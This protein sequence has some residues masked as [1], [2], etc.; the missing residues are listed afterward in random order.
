MIHR[1]GT[2]TS[3]EDLKIA[4]RECP[5]DNGEKLKFE[6]RWCMHMENVQLAPVGTL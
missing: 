5:G 1:G 6:G 2:L 4:I 3:A